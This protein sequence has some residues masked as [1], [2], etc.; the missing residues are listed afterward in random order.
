VR[1][2]AGA[3]GDNFILMQDNARPHTARLVM[4]YLYQEGIEIMDWPTRSPD[5]NPIERMWDYIHRRISQRQNRPLTLPDLTQL[6]T[7]KCK[8]L[9]QELIAT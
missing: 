6:L 3:V 7:L 8:G 2:F 1:P 4:H 5:F 9:P